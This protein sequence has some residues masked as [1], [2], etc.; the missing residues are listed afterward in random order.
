MRTARLPYGGRRVGNPQ[1]VS[2]ALI[3]V[4]V[5]VWAAIQATGRASSRLVDVLALLPQAAARLGPGHDLVLVHGVGDGAWWQP[6]TSLFTHVAALHVGF[7][8]LALYF[9]GPPLEQV[10]GRAR[11]LALYLAA[12][13]A[14]SAAVML[15]S[16]PHQQTLGASG[17]IFG[18]MG[19]LLVLVVKLRG[20]VQT[21]V[22]W[23]VLNLVFTFTAPHISW[24]GHLG[25]LAG[26]ALVGAAMIYAP[27]SNR[28][29]VQWGATAVVALLA[30]ALIVVRAA[31]LGP[32]FTA[33]G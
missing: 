5:V 16:D 22:M 29:L 13:L 4:N 10:L 32:A 26:G 18:L 15:W 17:A 23:I 11:F 20:S 6:V 2:V 14:G 33:A 8:M 30:V 19:A 21:L 28:A 12:G 9:L 7:N 1:L 27:R 24:E 31:S 3:A 25:G